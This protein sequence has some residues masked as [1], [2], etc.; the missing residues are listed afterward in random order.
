MSN[1]HLFIEDEIYSITY[2]PKTFGSEV[3]INMIFKFIEFSGDENYKHLLKVIIISCAM[4]TDDVD[5][6]T[7]F[8][9]NFKFSK[10]GEITFWEIADDDDDNPD[11]VTR[12][13]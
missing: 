12:L 10:P 9:K 4:Y 7:H 5:L 2:K 11:I 1:K 6:R 13:S 3:E 8:Y